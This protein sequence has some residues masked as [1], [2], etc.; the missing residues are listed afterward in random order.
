MK[1]WVGL[2]GWPVADGLP[3]CDISGHPSAAGRAQDRESSPAKDRRYTTVP[4]NQENECICHVLY[5]SLQR[6]CFNILCCVLFLYMFLATD[7][8]ICC[9]WHCCTLNLS[10]YVTL[11]SLTKVIWHTVR[12][13]RRRT[14]TVQSYSPGGAN[15]HS[16]L[17]RGPTPLSNPNCISISTAVFAQLS[18]ECTV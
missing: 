14:R 18:A 10:Y 7:E 8:T 9:C 4:R 3:T 1:G 5:N 11:I 15:V 13:H 16:R 6:L 17:I 12:P 2:V